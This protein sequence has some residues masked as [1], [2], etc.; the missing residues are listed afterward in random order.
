[1]QGNLS[2]FSGFAGD[3]DAFRPKPPS[4]LK[5]ILPLLAQVTRPKRIVDIGSG[6]GL[7]TRYWAGTSEVVIGVEP[8][9]DM[10][11]EATAVTTEMN[12]H[13]KNGLSSR[14]R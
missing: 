1:M 6:T 4:T 7:S 8:N 5:D 9:A 11:T 3:Y 13:Y 10:R 14:T 2:R 12:I